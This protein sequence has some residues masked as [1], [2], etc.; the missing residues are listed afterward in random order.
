MDI[1]QYLKSIDKLHGGNA[2]DVGTGIG[3]TAKQLALIGFNV[4]AVDNKPQNLEGENLNFIEK[5]IQD[6]EIKNN[7]YDLIFARN[8]LPFLPSEEATFKTIGKLYQ[9]LKGG[10]VMYFSIFG[11]RDDWASK[12]HMTFI[13]YD[14]V[15]NNI[16]G[17]KLKTGTEYF[18]GKTMSGDLKYWHIHHFII[19][20]E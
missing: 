11:P 2:L 6:L 8:I 7:H 12:K 19:E 5:D 3:Q 14:K 20:K 17:K 16:P 18:W 13:E 1:L 15:L 9:G 10:G 4:D